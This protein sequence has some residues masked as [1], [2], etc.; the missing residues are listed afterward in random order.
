MNEKGPIT[1]LKIFPCFLLLFLFLAPVTKAQDF[2]VGLAAGGSYYLGD[3]NPGTHFKNTQLAFG[4]L[5]RY[6]LS[7]RWTVR[8]S[9]MRGTVKGSSQSSEY[10]PSRNLVFESNV[11]D[12]S[13]VAEFNFF[14]FFTGSRRNG[15]TPFIYGGVGVTFFNPMSGGQALQ[16]LGTEG[17]NVGYD[18]R[19]PYSLV[20]VNI[21]FGVGG[22]LSLSKRFCLTLFWEMHK[23]F[24]DYLDDVSTTY[25][26]DGTAINP[27]DPAQAL[28]DPSMNHMPGMKRGNATTD[29]W[30]SFSG[31]TLTYKFALGKSKR[32]RDLKGQQ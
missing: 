9:A 32:C 31:V 18:G 5:G 29:D 19:K 12:I 8:L 3:L 2:E 21:P 28:S 4:V 20:Q 25:Y 10:M 11:T 27:D 26:L 7:D 15:I 24:N 14:P 13:A 17:Q 1:G 30:Y 22:K 6:N 23:L 16:P